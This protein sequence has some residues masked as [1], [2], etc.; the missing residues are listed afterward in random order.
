MLIYQVIVLVIFIV[1]IVLCLLNGVKMFFTSSCA[2]IYMLDQ[3]DMC[4]NVLNSVKGFIST[5]TV[6]PLIPIEET[7]NAK[8]LLMCNLIG[9]K[10]QAS[11]I[12]TTIFSFLSAI[13]QYQLVIESAI[14]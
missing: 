12:Y 11:V 14:L 3:A 13:F 2:Q 5:F 10:M 6:D 7:C 9:E 8:N 1:A 4:T